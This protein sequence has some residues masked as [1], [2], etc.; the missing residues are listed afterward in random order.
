MKR[1]S[2]RQR[3]HMDYKEKYAEC[4][5]QLRLLKKVSCREMSLAL[6]QSEGFINKIEIE[7]RYRLCK[8]SFVPATI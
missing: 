2:E 3:K 5:T 6:G 1:V 8:F 7:K 4:L